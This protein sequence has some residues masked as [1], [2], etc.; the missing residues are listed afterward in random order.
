MIITVMLEKW[1]WFVVRRSRAILAVCL[2]GAVLSVYC[3]VT[4]PGRL[5][6]ELFVDRS[7]EAYKAQAI[8]QDKFGVGVP[9]LLLVVTARQG[10]VDDPTVAREAQALVDR[11]AAEPG[12]TDVVS[13]WSSGRPE[14][15]RSKAGNRAL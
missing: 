4:L 5:S 1:G 11:L 3:Y 9:N 13:Y 7:S 6:L 2:L 8:L 15:L 12:V 10:S 14:L